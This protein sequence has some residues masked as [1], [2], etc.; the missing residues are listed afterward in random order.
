MRANLTLRR[1]E[2]LQ[3]ELIDGKIDHDVILE[4][5]EEID[6]CFLFDQEALQMDD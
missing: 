1:K 2:F 3:V 5:F 6:I 4:S